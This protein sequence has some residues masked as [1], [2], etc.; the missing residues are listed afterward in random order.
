MGRIIVTCFPSSSSISG[1]LKP[2]I[3]L[4]G[5]EFEDCALRCTDRSR[6]HGGD[7]KLIGYFYSDCPTWTH[8]RK[9]T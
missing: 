9:P 7:P 6:P 2:A 5:T 8:T 4:F 1:N 3:G